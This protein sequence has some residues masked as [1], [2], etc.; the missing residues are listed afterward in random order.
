MRN[1]CVALLLTYCMVHACMLYAADFDLVITGGRVMD[2]ETDLDAIRNVGIRDGQILSISTKPLTGART[3]DASGLVVAPGFIDLHAHGQDVRSNHFQAADGVTTAL[4][5]EQG[6]L[7]VGAWLESRRG[8]SPIHYGA[9]S[10]HLA[11]RINLLGGVEV[12]NP[13]YLAAADR[14]AAEGGNYADAHLAGAQLD[15]LVGSIEAGIRDGGLGIGSGITYMPGASHEEIYALFKLAARYQVPLFTHIRQARYMGGDLL[16][17]LQ[18]VLADAAA[19]GAP[20]HVVHINS[21]LDESARLAI[22]MIRGMRANGLDIT[23]ETYPYTAGSTRLESALFD[24]YQGDYGQLQWTETGE[25]LTRETFEEYRKQGGWVI[26][27]GRNEET[28]RW[29]VA[30]PDVMIASDGVPYV[31]DFSHPR[32]AG[33]FARVLGHYVRDEGALPLM[34]ALRKMT[35][36]P[37]QR[38]EK[39]APAMRRKGRVQEGMD[40]DLTLFAPAT[41]LDQ[42]TY[43]IPA[44]NSAGIHH[45]LVKGVA[46]VTDGA[47]VENV[48]PGEAIRSV[49]Q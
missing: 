3:I 14:S 26:I 9:A 39:F 37:A 32:S 49:W 11:G 5:L 44:R 2:P 8:R 46:V 16:A 19:T 22:D 12:G 43:S 45:V 7:P 31:G 6:V 1:F 25:R 29:L 34:L 4:E 23:T 35:L 20:L 36:D 21:S 30:Q 47:I 13:V 15:A 27:H 41:V 17:P 40:A 38:L 18:E 24:D 48:F 42:A 33:T 10:G 28:S